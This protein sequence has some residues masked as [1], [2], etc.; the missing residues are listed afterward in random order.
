MVY[1]LCRSEIHTGG[2]TD[3]IYT[4]THKDRRQSLIRSTAIDVADNHLI[5]PVVM[6]SSVCGSG[7]ADA[8][9]R[10]ASITRQNAST[11][12]SA[13][14]TSPSTHIVHEKAPIAG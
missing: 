4:V 14:E 9:R 6:S 7:S 10:R 2:S 5:P 8:G 1:N 3:V 11:E 12:S 13:H